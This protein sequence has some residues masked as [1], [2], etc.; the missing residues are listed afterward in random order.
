LVLVG[1]RLEDVCLFPLHRRKIVAVAFGSGF[2]WFGFMT[3][4]ATGAGI[5][6][7]GFGV[8]LGWETLQDAGGARAAFYLATLV[9]AL[10]AA[11]GTGLWWFVGGAGE[12]RLAAVPGRRVRDH[13]NEDGSAPG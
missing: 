11:L 3:L 5:A 4:L 2:S 13:R 10:V 9:I 12:R 1:G 8:A 7:F 6:A